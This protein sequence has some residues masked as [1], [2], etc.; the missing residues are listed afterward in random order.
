M[1]KVILDQLIALSDAEYV[2]NK[3]YAVEYLSQK[4]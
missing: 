2:Q 1:R 3:D 4:R